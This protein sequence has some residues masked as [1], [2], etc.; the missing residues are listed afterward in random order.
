MFDN[1]CKFLAESFSTD[2]ASWLVGEP[3]ELT[4]LSPSELS[5]EPIRADSLILRQAQAVVL[6]CEFQTDP[7]DTMGFRMAD[8]ALR[9]YRR[10]PQK[11]LVQVV[12]YL[13]PTESERVY[14]TRFI[15]NK[16]TH[17]FRVIRLWEQPTEIFLQRPGLYPYAALS[18][19]SDRTG[20]LRQ[21]A[22]RIDGLTDRRQQSNL[23]AAT[24]ILAGLLLDQQVIQRVLR[25][26]LMR[27][28]V[29]YQE[30]REEIWEEARQELLPIAEQQ[31]RQAEARSL[32]LRLLQQKFAV[33]P[34]P[35]S[36]LIRSLNLEQLEALALA[37]LNFSSLTD[38]ERWLAESNNR[39]DAS[40]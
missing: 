38:L 5:L 20:I 21:V 28:S 10:F 39:S 7:D 12:V 32:V 40:N 33:L 13:R 19:T 18:Q 1:I 3:V 8:Y 9:I 14:Q 4:Q 36:D 15:A 22:Q 23:A 11:R 17:E 16:L 27:E 24:G 6:H 25:R 37:L 34:D 29:I 35:L 30:W 26:D 31:G 2:L